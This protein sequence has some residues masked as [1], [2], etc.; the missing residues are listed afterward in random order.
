MKSPQGAHYALPSVW[1]NVASA[2]N[3]NAAM[4]Y[5]SRLN[6]ACQTALVGGATILGVL[7]LAI[8]MVSSAEAA[9]SPYA[10]QEARA[11]KSLSA[12]EVDGLLTGKG[13][14]FAKAAELNGY[15]GPA[16]VLEL[17]SD[18]Q[19]TDEQ[20][21]RTRAIH[22]QME[23][24]AKAAGA[25]LVAAERELEDLFQQ[26]RATS[27]LLSAALGKVAALQA[28]VRAAHLN[29]HIE[30]TR[31]LTE[32]QV[33]QYQRLRGYA[34]AADHRHRHGTHDEHR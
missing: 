15:P 3:R 6:V 33:V 4:K 31:L 24:E 5:T 26:R 21:T 27:A 29:A 23:T 10:G 34:A 17:A 25:A 8:N 1:A 20:L 11:I 19:L 30:Q 14:G 9:E 28:Q 22:T 12:T 7:T 2:A 16:H 32:Q 13:L 18:L